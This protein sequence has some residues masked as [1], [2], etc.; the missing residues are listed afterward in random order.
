MLELGVREPL[1]TWRPGQPLEL[2]PPGRAA[3]LVLHD[4][5]R[6]TWSDQ[7]TLLRWLDRTAAT[8]RVV[9]T[10][11]LPMWPRVQAGGFSEMLYYRLNTVCL[12]AGTR[13]NADRARHA[14]AFRR[15]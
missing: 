1:Q 5:D 13:P 10:A 2:P 3:T 9:S 12:T 8:V 15:S 11:A 7:E 4:V 6:M 14:P